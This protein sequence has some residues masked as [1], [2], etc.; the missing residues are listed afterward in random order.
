MVRA[1]DLIVGDRDALLLVQL[2]DEDVRVPR[3]R[4]P[5]GGAVDDEARR[6]AGGEEREVV[7]VGR[8]RDADEAGDLGPPHQEL[9]ADPGA[10]REPRDP[11][12]LGV[13]VHRL[14]VV[15]R[16]GRVAELADALVVLALAAPDAAEVEPQ[17]GEA[18][19]VKGVMQVVDDTVVHRPAELRVRMQDDR[20][21]RVLLLLRVVTSLETTLRSGEN[22]FG[23]GSCRLATR[24]VIV[25]GYGRIP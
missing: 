19:L 12:V 25:D 24:P 21:R 9:H 15:E 17:H 4:H 13:L 18:Q 11:A 23:H 7:H 3:R 22:D 5:V 10:E 20:D 6:R 2:A 16:R 8:R 1:L 14:Q